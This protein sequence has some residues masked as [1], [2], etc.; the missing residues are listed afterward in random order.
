MSHCRPRL[1]VEGKH[2]HINNERLSVCQLYFGRNFADVSTRCSSLLLGE[3]LVETSEKFLSEIKLVY[4]EPIIVYARANREAPSSLLSH[5]QLRGTG[6]TSSCTGLSWGVEVVRGPAEKRRLL[7]PT[8]WGPALE[9][10]G[11][12]PNG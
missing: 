1:P 6:H 7:N 9:T 10:R 12:G 5:V 11:A 3:R 4:R 8:A 2:L